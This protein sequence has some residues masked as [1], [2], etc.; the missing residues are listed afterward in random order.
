MIEYPITTKIGSEVMEMLAVHVKSLRKNSGISQEQLAARLG[1]GVTTVNNIESGYL[2]AP[3]TKILE[4]LAETFFVTVNDLLHS[5]SPDVGERSKMV[6]IVSSVSSAKPFVE[7]SKIVE[8][9]FI[10]RLDMRGFEYMG[11]KMPDKAMIEEAIKENANVIIRQN[12]ILKNGDIIAATYHNH[13][14]VIRTYYREGNIVVLKAAN[15]SGLYPDIVLDVDKDNFH[16]IGKVVHWTNFA[17]K[18]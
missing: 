17:E 16:P 14:A 3:G 10:D 11:I 8:T 15:S 6:H 9:A 4:K 12:D 7:I 1:V 18:K 13:D 2:T 5:V